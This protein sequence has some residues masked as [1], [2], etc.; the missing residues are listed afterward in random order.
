MKKKKGMK[1]KEKERNEEKSQKGMKKERKKEGKKRKERENKR[2]H[3]EVKVCAATLPLSAFLLG[4]LSSSLQQAVLDC[5]HSWTFS[6]V[7][8]P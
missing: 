1:K 8:C 2:T 4:K 5:Q 7:S 3:T 6:E